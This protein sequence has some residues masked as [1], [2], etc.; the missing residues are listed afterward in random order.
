MTRVGQIVR[1]RRQWLCPGQWE[2]ERTAIWMFRRQD[3]DL[4]HQQI[5]QGASMSPKA[6]VPLIY[7][8]FT[9]FSEYFRVWKFFLQLFQKMYVSLKKNVWW[10]Y[11]R[12]RSVYLCQSLNQ[13]NQLNQLINRMFFYSLAIA[14]IS[15]LRSY[16]D[17]VSGGHAHLGDQSHASFARILGKR[18]SNVSENQTR[19]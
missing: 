9:P 3:D 11:L 6:M 18:A 4:N 17:S 10:P 1:S 7:F 2:Q 8:R 16:Y 12:Y 13:L 15:E 14:M 5:I 19:E